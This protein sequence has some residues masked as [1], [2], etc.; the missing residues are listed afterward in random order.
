MHYTK[1]IIFISNISI[2][3]YCDLFERIFLNDYVTKTMKSYAI[4]SIQK[5][6]I[7]QL[8]PTLDHS[9][10][11]SYKWLG[12]TF[13]CNKYINVILISSAFEAVL[14][15]PGWIQIL[16]SKKVL[17]RTIYFHYTFSYIW[18][19]DW[20]IVHGTRSGK[21]IDCLQSSLCLLNIRGCSTIESGFNW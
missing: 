21:D 19:R 10:H 8:M 15:K 20:L 5:A 4:G 13:I 12:K 6:G 14:L 18:W 16:Q 9:N 1:K 3:I 17:R 2:I 11:K 7:L